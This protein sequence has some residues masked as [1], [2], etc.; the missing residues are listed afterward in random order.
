MMLLLGRLITLLLLLLRYPRRTL[1]NLPM[2]LLGFL[3]L[4]SKRRFVRHSRMVARLDMG[5]ML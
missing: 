1:L 4:I 5:F 3:T 2:L